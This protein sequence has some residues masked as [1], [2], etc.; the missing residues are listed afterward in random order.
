MFPFQ[1]FTHNVKFKYLNKRFREKR[2]IVAFLLFLDYLE[3]QSFSKKTKYNYFTGSAWFSTKLSQFLQ[4]CSFC[5]NWICQY[6]Q[7]EAVN[8]FQSD[9]DQLTAF[10]PVAIFVLRKSAIKWNQTCCLENSRK[11]QM[12]SNTKNTVTISRIAHSYFA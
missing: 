3:L 9:D 6:F 10:L 7:L 4:N 11:R 1:S 5:M 12:I 2:R 8:S